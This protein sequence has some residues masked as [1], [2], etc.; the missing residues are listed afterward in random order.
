[1]SG[2][3][4]YSQKGTTLKLWEVETGK[5]LE[6]IE[7]QT[8]SVYSCRFSHDGNLIAS[9]ITGGFLKLLDAKIST[10]VYSYPCIGIVKSC[11]FSP[12]GNAICCGD[13]GGTLYILEMYGFGT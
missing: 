5:E 10:D 9:G 11:D 8:S 2:S 13:F 12:M 7:G 6:T 4:R 3:Y 1:V